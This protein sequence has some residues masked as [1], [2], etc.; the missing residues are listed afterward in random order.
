MRVAKG[1]RW[2]G[3]A[4]SMQAAAREPELADAAPRLGLTLTKKVGGAVIRNR[5]RRRLREALRLADHLPA[6][7]GHDYVVIGRIEAIRVPFADL[8]SELARAFIGVHDAGRR[9]RRDAPK[10]SA[11]PG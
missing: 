7:A 2:H 8:Q 11:A 4:L 3:K 10:T 9:K 1:K 5:A 6:R